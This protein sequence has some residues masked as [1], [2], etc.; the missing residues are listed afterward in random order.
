MFTDSIRE[1]MEYIDPAA[2]THADVGVIVDNSSHLIEITDTV[3]DLPLKDFDE[4]TLR[5]LGVTTGTVAPELHLYPSLAVNWDKWISDGLDKGEQAEIT[6]KYSRIGNCR[7]EAP[8]LN[9]EIVAS[10][11]DT[12]VKRDKY[13]AN[14]QNIRGSAMAALGSAITLLLN[15]KDDGVDQHQLLSYLA[16]AGR[17]LTSAHRLDSISRKAFIIPSLDKKLKG[18]LDGIKSDSFLFG[19]NL[20]EKIKSAK[21]IEK[22]GA[23]LKQQHPAMKPPFRAV[24]SKNWK[25]SPVQS[26]RRGYQGSNNLR[27]SQ[28]FVKFQGRQMTPHQP[29]ENRQFPGRSRGQ[30]QGIKR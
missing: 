1:G 24:N 29:A 5:I 28:N 19:E 12:A 14:A 26:Y 17:L 21:S 15:Q 20:A 23:E 3:P 25:R 8:K 16:D 18:I 9:P 6:A 13:L 22:A 11:Y 30:N 7:L 27:N 2:S 10:I 4:E